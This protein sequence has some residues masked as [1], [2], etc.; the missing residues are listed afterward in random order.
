M[1]QT[2][3]MSCKYGL[4]AAFLVGFWSKAKT[5]EVMWICKVFEAI[6]TK[7]VLVKAKWKRILLV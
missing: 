2:K 4:A 5:S 1:H 7:S 3:I 6:A